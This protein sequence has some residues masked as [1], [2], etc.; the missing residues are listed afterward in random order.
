MK[1]EWSQ[2]SCEVRFKNK[3][4]V[5]RCTLSPADMQRPASTVTRTGWTDSGDSFLSTINSALQ[6]T[7]QVPCHW[8][9]VS[10]PSQQ[11]ARR[12][13]QLSVQFAT[14]KTLKWNIIL[15][16][17][18]GEVVSLLVFNP[19]ELSTKLA[20]Y[21]NRSKLPEYLINCPRPR[22]FPKRFTL[23]RVWGRFN[24]MSTRGCLTPV[25]QLEMSF[26]LHWETQSGTQLVEPG[27]Y[28]CDHVCMFV[29]IFVL[30]APWLEKGAHVRLDVAV[31][32]S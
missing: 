15:C 8:W 23:Y 17:C 27:V 13:K 3:S 2:V 4:R 20:S 29:P 18:K 26:K 32:F 19:Q 25:N 31:Y 24:I 6:A 14:S 22:V 28:F 12:I 16:I 30:C 9:K 11:H 1:S 5:K 21:F 7:E 10:N